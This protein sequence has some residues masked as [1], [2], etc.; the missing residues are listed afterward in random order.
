MDII[1]DGTANIFTIS[2]F[3]LD[4]VA[5]MNSV[6]SV[7]SLLRELMVLF[8]DLNFFSKFKHV[9]CI[10]SKILVRVSTNIPILQR[11]NAQAEWT[12]YE[13]F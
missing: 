7:T 2:L 11:S 3:C 5:V 4:T 6:Y 8:R 13:I 1:D 10:D 12:N 9:H